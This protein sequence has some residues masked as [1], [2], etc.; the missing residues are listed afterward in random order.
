MSRAPLTHMHK[1]ILQRGKLTRSEL[2]QHGRVN[3]EQLKASNKIL[4]AFPVLHVNLLAFVEGTQGNGPENLRTF[5]PR[6][7]KY[8]LFLRGTL[9]LSGTKWDRMTSCIWLWIL[10]LYQ[11]RETMACF[12]CL[13]PRAL[14]RHPAHSRCSIN[15]CQI[16]E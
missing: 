1:S 5:A 10:H 16:G 2:Q 3:E 4:G 9:L 12:Q 13:I 11:F 15:V 6:S 14:P 8:C 7:S